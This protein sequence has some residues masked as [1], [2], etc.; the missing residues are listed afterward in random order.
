MRVRE[1]PGSIG[2]L[3]LSWSPPH[4]LGGL[5][6]LGYQLEVRQGRSFNW[7]PYPLSACG[8]EFKFQPSHIIT[9]IQPNKEYFFR[10]SAVNKEG[11]GLP[12]TADDSYVKNINL[13]P[14]KRVMGRR[15]PSDETDSQSYV[16]PLLQV[17]WEW[18]PLMIE[19]LDIASRSAK[20]EPIDF[21]P[22][23]DRSQTNYTHQSVSPSLDGSYKF[24]VYTTYNEG[25][26]QPVES[27]VVLASQ[28][29]VG[30][31]DSRETSHYIPPVPSVT[32]RSDS[33]LGYELEWEAPEGRGAEEIRGFTLED[34][35]S[36]KQ[37]WAPLIEIPA[38]APR[39]LSLAAPYTPDKD[40]KMRIISHGATGKSIPTEFGLYQSPRESALSKPV[41]RDWT[42]LPSTSGH[43]SSALYPER[44]FPRR[45]IDDD[46]D[47]ELAMITGY[48][49]GSV[50]V[51][52]FIRSR[53]QIAQDITQRT[54]TPYRTPSSLG[55]LSVLER[56]GLD[57]NR[58]ESSLY[59]TG[60]LT[61]RPGTSTPSGLL[62]TDQLRAQIVS[63]TSVHLSWPEPS[64]LLAPGKINL[65]DIQ[66]WEPTYAR[67]VSIAKAPSR[68]TD[69]TLTGLRTTDENG[70]WFRVVPL[71]RDGESVGAPYQMAKPLYPRSQHATVPSSVWGVE[72]SPAYGLNNMDKRTIQVNWM[73]PSNDGGSDILGY[74]LIVYDADTGD[75]QEIVVS[76]KFLNAKIDS[77]EAFHVYR[78][79]ITAFNRVGDS[80]PVTST[81]PLHPETPGL[82]PLPLP[83]SDFRAVLADQFGKEYC[84]CILS[85]KPPSLISSPV[86]FYVIEKWS[87]QSKQWIPFKKVTADIH[88]IEVT[89]LLDDV[90]YGFRIRSQNVSGLSEP[91]CLN[92][93]IRPNLAKEKNIL[94]LPP[95]APGG[96]LELKPIS[97]PNEGLS[98]LKEVTEIANRVMELCWSQPTLLPDEVGPIRGYVIEAR[99][100]GQ[101]NWALLGRLPVTRDRYWNIVFG[102][103]NTS[104]SRMPSSQP[105]HRPASTLTEYSDVWD[106]SI[107]QL[108]A[109]SYP[110]T[111]ML[112]GEP[113][114]YE[115][116][117]YSENEFGVSE[118]LYLR[119]K[120]I[121]SSMAVEPLYGSYSPLE[122]S[123]KFISPPR[124]PIQIETRPK[125]SSYQDRIQK[126][127]DT[128]TPEDLVLRWKPPYDT[129]NISSYEVVYRTPY[130]MKWQ[131]IGR[132][133]LS[134]TSLRIPSSLLHDFPQTVHVGVR[135]VGEYVPELDRRPYS[136]TVEEVLS[137]PQSIFTSSSY[138][139][140]PYKTTKDEFSLRPPSEV[141]ASVFKYSPDKESPEE[142]AV[143]WR[144]PS[145]K[146]VVQRG[147]DSSPDS[148]LILSRELGHSEWKEIQTIP[149]DLTN[150]HIRSS[151]L[152]QGR[153]IYIGVAPVRGIQIG[154]IMSTLDTIKL[155][156]PANSRRFSSRSSLPFISGEPLT[157]LPDGPD[158][159]R[160]Q[161]KPTEALIS[162]LPERG[163]SDYRLEMRRPY[164][165]EWKSVKIP[166][167]IDLINGISPI[168]SA[169]E[170]RLDNLKPGERIELRI[171]TRPGRSG[172]PI[173]VTDTL[174]YQFIPPY[175]KIFNLYFHFRC[176]LYIFIFGY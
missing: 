105:L 21:V 132:T 7:K 90:D 91:L 125:S 19:R 143:A 40:Y 107:P 99:R 58:I 95:P 121:S 136:E 150:T 89:H 175:G 135:S 72:I 73:R 28:P 174:F 87:S 62:I 13:A 65:Y 47:L 46:F 98:K 57:L 106:R 18:T 5:P 74:R 37:K 115:F 68:V 133:G 12:L 116:R 38:T 172:P 103:Q 144:P 35:D 111:S 41:S 39:Q 29:S 147:L 11:V 167:N 33:R 151:L 55:R 94:A 129:T 45:E 149:S 50:D 124:G 64:G 169:L 48:E 93:H 127:S 34:W 81:V 161:W 120:P 140:K 152:P 139:H 96:P 8:P 130:E 126:G 15:I 49:S 100:S 137:I 109:K 10:V 51:D 113:K 36:K 164:D 170:Y 101:E 30:R 26:S 17:S 173:P 171:A 118:P 6:I 4:E 27:G 114:D 104:Y 70:W 117:L 75:D 16:K 42:T 92:T 2:T 79:T 145:E 44:G 59:S 131:P 153:D 148:Y 31:P 71:G 25:A 162:K 32:L 43:P 66:K 160:V 122:Y 3:E 24:R 78:I 112:P 86:D 156:E 9:D 134:D 20:W 69:Y 154:P 157:V 67:W 146:S 83:P 76:P 88:E 14:P 165:L 85:W 142:V 23:N 119:P 54:A 155:A 80:I 159:I 52:E 163:I 82:P 128:T 53:R 84:S 108:L 102:P 56:E 166:K 141:R 176:A 138:Q 1:V 63:P 61:A 110:S 123:P 77:L 60:R 97:T 22:I 158:A 168:T